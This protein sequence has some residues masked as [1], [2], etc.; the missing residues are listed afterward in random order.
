MIRC[1]T[2]GNDLVYSPIPALYFC[3]ERM[4]GDNIKIRTQCKP[5]ISRDASA[6]D[7][8]AL[9]DN[10]AKLAPELDVSRP[11]SHEMT[12]IVRAKGRSRA[13]LDSPV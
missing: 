10:I 4:N 3:L 6:A 5:W 12:P 13:K 2:C 11:K 8:L 1:P 7:L 9:T